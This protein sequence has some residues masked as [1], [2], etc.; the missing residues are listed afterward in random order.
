MTFGFGFCSVLYGAGFGS[1]SCTFFTFG[2]DSVL[3]K[4]WVLIRFVLAG[5]GFSPISNFYAL[6]QQDIIIA[7]EIIRIIRPV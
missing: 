1:R 5:F 4:S 3:G 2:F 6:G 7:D